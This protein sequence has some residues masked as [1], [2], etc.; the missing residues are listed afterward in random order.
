MT[1]L[2]TNM[3]NPYD[4]DMPVEDKEQM[5]RN[6]PDWREVDKIIELIE[7]QTREYQWRV[8]YFRVGGHLR[9]DKQL[10]GMLWRSKKHRNIQR[11]LAKKRK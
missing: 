4:Y 6:N 7:K 1:P 5:V 9:D 2:V 8:I 10:A 3:P 11:S